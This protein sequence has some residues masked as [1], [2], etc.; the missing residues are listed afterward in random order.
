MIGERTLC[1]V[2]SE[3]ASIIF[4]SASEGAGASVV[5]AMHAGVIPVVTSS[6]G[7]AEEAEAYIIEEATVEGVKKMIEKIAKMDSKT[8]EKDAR[9]VWNFARKNHTKENF[10]KNFGEFIDNTLKL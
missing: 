10:S 8:L 3:Y 1:D 6:S 2:M 9:R 5:Q 4:P 7:I